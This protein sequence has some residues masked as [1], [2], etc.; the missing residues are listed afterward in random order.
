[1]KIISN[2]PLCSERSLH[3]IGEKDSQTQQC[4]NCGYVTYTKLKLNDSKKEDNEIFKSFTED[5]VKWSRVKNDYIWIPSIITLPMGMLYP[6]NEKDKM[7]WALAEMIDIPEEEQKNYPRETGDGF[8]T[9]RFDTENAL[10]FE[11]FIYAMS[12]LNNKAK[13]MN[14]G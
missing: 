6:M 3:V 1:M 7:K 8:Y 9:R 4:I 13:G 14:N 5:M 10:I 2:C 11:E 12:E